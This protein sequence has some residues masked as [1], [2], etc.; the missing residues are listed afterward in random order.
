M[1]LTTD[2]TSMD[3]GVIYSLVGAALGLSW[4]GVYTVD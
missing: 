4:D 1:W 2:V 3:V